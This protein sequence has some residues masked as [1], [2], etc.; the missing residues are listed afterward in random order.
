MKPAGKISLW[1]AGIG[2]LLLIPAAGGKLFD[3]IAG[4]LADKEA[5]PIELKDVKRVPAR[6]PLPVDLSRRTKPVP[7]R[8]AEAAKERYLEGLK[9][10]QEE[11]YDKAEEV[12][13]EAADLDPNNLE[14]RKGLKRIEGITSKTRPE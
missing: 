8:D 1:V 12:W 10:F 7:E 11:N 13:L 9:R 2:I 6:E 5:A 3:A 4:K 14:V